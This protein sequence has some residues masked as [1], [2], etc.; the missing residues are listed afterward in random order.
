MF[1]SLD[2][3]NLPPREHVR[4]TNESKKNGACRKNPKMEDHS[5]EDKRIFCYKSTQKYANLESK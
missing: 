2:M 1:L 3:A 5:R 4:P